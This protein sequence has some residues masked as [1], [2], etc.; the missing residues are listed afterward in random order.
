MLKRH[1]PSQQYAN[2][3]TI[4]RRFAHTFAGHGNT[5]FFDQR[6]LLVCFA[7]RSSKPD[8]SSQYQTRDRH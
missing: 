2:H 5:T 7:R 8:L 4:I 6:H 1:R 3:Y